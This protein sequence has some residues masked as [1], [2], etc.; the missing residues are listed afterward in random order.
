MLFFSALLLLCALPLLVLCAE[1]YYKLLGIDRDASDREIKKAYRT[2]SKKFHPDKNPDDKD[3]SER[4]VAVA[5]AYDALIDP[6]TRKIYDQYGH[7]GLAKHKQGG[8]H[9]G[10]H[11]DPFD[12]FSRFFGGSGHFG[13]GGERRGPN[14]EVRLT[15]PL[16]DFYNG[17]EVQ[18]TMERQAICDA[19]EGSGSADGV[20]DTCDVCGGR[21]FR[22]QKHMLA[23]GI[24]Q[25]VQGPCD[26]CGGKGKQVRHAC[27]VCGGSRVVQ[28]HETHTVHVE[29]GMPKGARITFENEAD[30]SPDWVAGD[31]VVQLIEKDPQLGDDDATRTDGSFFRRKGDD[32]FWR[33][34]LSLREAWM[35]DWTRNISHLDGHVVRLGRKRGQV[36]QPN[37]VEI[38]KGEGMPIWDR[39]SDQ[40]KF[41]ALHVEYVVVL[42]DQMDKSMEKE[43]WGVWDKW[44]MKKGV[45][46]LK[47]SG[48]PSPHDEL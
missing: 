34:V 1:D 17:A 13:H 40:L 35:G 33:E 38:V 37:A 12:L 10:H 22:V 46:L 28:E 15:V 27:K 41:G 19:C 43:F 26:A 7:D 5:E 16:R 11:H 32:L 18:F 48:R 8:G 2:L 39:E 3:A 24:F 47:D 25:Q 4:F 31:L 6:E 14:T 42:P 20:V 23:P 30:E 9:P 36:V 29:R 45:D 21:G 44:R